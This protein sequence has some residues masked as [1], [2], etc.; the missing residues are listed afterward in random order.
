M[1]TIR[2]NE[3][4]ILSGYDNRS[5]LYD[6]GECVLRKINVDYF[7][8]IATV[9]NIYKER[10]LEQYGVVATEI[11]QCNCS[12]RHK[13]YTIAYP[14]EWTANMYKDAV[15]FHLR[16][17]VELDK[18]G[19]TLKDA[20]PNNIVFHH[21]APVF[22]DFSSLVRTEKLREEK[23]LVEDARHP[24]P[25]FAVVE[26][27]L[28][29]F[30][31]IPFVALLRKDYP[32]VRR[33]LSEQACNCCAP[34]PAWKNFNFNSFS[35]LICDTPLKYLLKLISPVL[36]VIDKRIVD[37][38]L[39]LAGKELNFIDFIKELTQLVAAADVTPPQSGYL[40][41]YE[42]KKENFDFKDDSSWNNKQKNVWT[43]LNSCRPATVLDIGANTGWFSTL[44]ERF[45][46]NVIATDIDES[47]I[48]S[49]Y[50]F[51]KKERLRILPLALSFDDLTREI[52]GVDDADP[53]YAGRDFKATPLFLPATRRLKSELVLCL[54]L[55]HHLVL[56]MG[57]EFGAV[58][59]VLADLTDK[60]LVLEFVS[61][62]DE[63]IL[64][65]PSFFKNIDRF[66]VDN[67][68][69]NLAMEEGKK[70]FSSVRILDSEP[71]TRKLLVLQ[72]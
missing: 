47:C 19:L 4:M 29:P 62:E 58:M 37:M 48:D 10:S 3:M 30:M 57:K 17:F 41:Y 46:A 7:D 36:P 22:V 71:E 21:C 23:W 72:K 14:Y 38:R 68:N 66:T 5:V 49:L 35:T 53:C 34:A 12:L 11:D 63:L 45:G 55:I 8:E 52:Y 61:I 16:L 39:L 26:R 51:A 67:Y 24:D 6:A 27:M 9:Y 18:H 59:A 44:A 2:D 64:G 33:M 54:G 56:G 20:L 70:F 43:I 25:R 31:L 42:N 15:L 65:E 60:Q 40:S 32:L 50:L 28:I 69:I 1:L 13:K